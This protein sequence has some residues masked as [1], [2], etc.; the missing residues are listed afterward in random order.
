MTRYA[1]SISAPCELCG[2]THVK[3]LFRQGFTL[4]GDLFGLQEG[5]LPLKL[6]H[7]VENRINPCMH[8]VRLYLERPGDTAERSFHTLHVGEGDIAGNRLDAANSRRHTAFGGNREDADV[9]GALDVKGVRLLAAAL[10]DA[11]AEALRPTIDTL[12]DK[13]GSA[14]IVLAS[15][16]GGRV[17]LVACVTKDLIGKLK[18][19]ELANFV[20]QQAGGKGGGRPDMAQA[21]GTEPEKLPDALASVKTWVEAKL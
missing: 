12:R 15:T 2:G 5:D 3:R 7:L 19:G 8:V 10:E 21:G 1:W 16:D 6:A 4:R 9:A 20:A 17:T 11:D 13:L 18:A 14:V